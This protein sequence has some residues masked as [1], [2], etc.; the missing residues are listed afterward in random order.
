MKTFR[1]GVVGLGWVAGA[2][3][4]TLKHVTGAEAA[5]VCSRRTLDPAELQARFGIRLL[6]RASNRS[7][8]RRCVRGSSCGRLRNRGQVSFNQL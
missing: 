2:H 6:E 4:E 8:D 5:A 1:V 7:Q 3:L